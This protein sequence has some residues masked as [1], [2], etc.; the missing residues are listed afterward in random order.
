VSSD[1][2]T[3]IFEKQKEIQAELIEKKSVLSENKARI[4]KLKEK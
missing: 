3:P 1:A 2:L 4:K